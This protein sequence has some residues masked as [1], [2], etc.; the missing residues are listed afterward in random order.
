[1]ILIYFDSVPFFFDTKSIE[2][3]WSQRRPRPWN[4]WSLLLL[5]R[6]GLTPSVQK[7]QRRK[8]LQRKPK[9]V[10]LRIS[11]ATLLLKAVIAVM[12]CLKALET[13]HVEISWGS[14][15]TKNLHRHNTMV[16]RKLWSLQ[17]QAKQEKEAGTEN[18][19]VVM[20]PNLNVFYLHVFLLNLC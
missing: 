14:I 18:S 19:G 13:A 7:L 10:K 20:W 17:V 4:L 6:R 5:A 3:R 12:N 11:K 1:M 16:A 9:C 2:H 15:A 8:Q